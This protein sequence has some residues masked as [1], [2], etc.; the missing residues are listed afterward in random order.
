MKKII[1]AKLIEGRIRSGRY[2][3]DDSYGL[4]GAFEIMGPCGAR[5]SIIANDADHPTANGFEHVSVS[6][7]NRCPNWPEM[8]FVKDLFWRDD[9]VAYQ[10]H[11]AKKD[12]VNCH[13]YTLHMWRHVER[14]PPLPDSLFV[15][16]K[17]AA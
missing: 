17:T 13:P 14:D 15:G 10:L 11:P 12:Y 1:D 9:E 3:S 2:V 6:L 7:H 8:N 4:T 5:L 16:P